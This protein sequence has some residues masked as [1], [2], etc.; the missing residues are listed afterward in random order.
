MA[1]P[2]SDRPDG[3]EPAMPLPRNQS[4]F[5]RGLP[6]T[7]LPDS[8]KRSDAALSI[9]TTGLPAIALLVEHCERRDRNGYKGG[10]RRAVVRRLLCHGSD[11]R[12]GPVVLTA[13]DRRIVRS[14]QPAAADRRPAPRRAA[15]PRRTNL[16]T[17]VN[18]DLELLVLAVAEVVPDDD[19]QLRDRR[20][21][22]ASRGPE[23][24]DGSVRSRCWRLLM[25]AGPGT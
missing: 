5:Q 6:R 17:T 15:L 4:R 11:S 25:N 24:V 23:G 12:V 13:A 20:Q 3:R 21:S 1:C 16:A 10:V 2:E 18:A 7:A 14:P 8:D 22:C 9:G 19:V